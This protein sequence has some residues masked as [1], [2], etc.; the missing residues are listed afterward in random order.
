MNSINDIFQRN[1]GHIGDKCDMNIQRQGKSMKNFLNKKHKI[2][3]KLNQTMHNL[4][5]GDASRR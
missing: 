1:L 4:Q 3:L 5:H 2:F